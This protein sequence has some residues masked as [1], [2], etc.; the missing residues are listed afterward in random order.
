M[1]GRCWTPSLM[2]VGGGRGIGMSDLWRRR[3][4]PPHGALPSSWSRAP[5]GHAPP[6]RNRSAESPFA[7]A[8]VREIWPV[9]MAAADQPVRASAA[10]AMAPDDR[11]V[12]RA[13]ARRSLEPST[14]PARR[15]AVQALEQ[16]RPQ[17]GQRRLP[18][19]PPP[20]SIRCGAVVSTRLCIMPPGRDDLVPYRLE[21]RAVAGWPA[22]AWI[23]GR[24]DAFPQFRDTG[25]PRHVSPPAGECSVAGLAARPRTVRPAPRIPRRRRSLGVYACRGLA[26]RP[27][28]RPLR[29][30]DVVSSRSNPEP[31][32]GRGSASFQPSLEC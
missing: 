20:V 23:A 8:L 27:S 28:P 13:G 1:S 11:R 30:V 2:I 26:P 21:V 31:A 4:L 5:A 17:P 10:T 24:G 25:T 18:P 19:P 7:G 16:R 32:Q 15:V 9:L 3:L 6:H 12:A 29:R 14:F 22:R